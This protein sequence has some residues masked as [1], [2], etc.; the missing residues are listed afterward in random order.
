MTVVER[1]RGQIAAAYADDRQ[2]PGIRRAGLESDS[3]GGI[4]FGLPEYLAWAEQIGFEGLW[5]GRP[6]KAA[7]RL[8]GGEPVTA[9]TLVVGPAPRQ[10]VDVVQVEILYR[11]VAQ[12]RADGPIAL[13]DQGIEQV[14]QGFAR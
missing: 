3:A 1:Q 10:L 7:R 8:D 14:L 5:P 4:A 9:R 11:A 12:L 13:F 6:G 2:R